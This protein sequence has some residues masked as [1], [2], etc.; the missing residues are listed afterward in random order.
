MIVKGSLLITLGLILKK[1][2]SAYLLSVKDPLE[3]E[4]WSDEPVLTDAT[5]S[6]CGPSRR[7][8][9]SALVCVLVE[10]GL[11]W[12]EVDGCGQAEL[13]LL[14]H[15]RFWGSS[16][17]LIMQSCSWTTLDHLHFCV[18]EIR[19]SFPIQLWP[20]CHFSCTR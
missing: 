4:L 10:V 5:L 2:P 6:H 18:C 12:A 13:V 1:Q 3:S 17:R 15:A 8:Q 19:S 9:V 7:F 11:L 20:F 16:G 14:F